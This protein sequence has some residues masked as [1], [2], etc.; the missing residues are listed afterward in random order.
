LKSVKMSLALNAWIN[1]KTENYIFDKFNLMPGEL[2][3]KKDLCEWILYCAKEMAGKLNLKDIV[4]NI[5]KIRLRLKKG[6]KEELIPLTR[7]KNIGRV[8]ARKLYENGIKNLRD[9]KKTDV[10]KLNRLLGKK[11]TLNLKKIL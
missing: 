10:K 1:E 9:I 11:L 5:E 7:I 3:A 2:Y 4:K 8:R 6:I